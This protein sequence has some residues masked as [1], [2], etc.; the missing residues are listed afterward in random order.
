MPGLRGEEIVSVYS[1]RSFG[2]AA[3]VLLC[4]LTEPARAQNA[5]KSAVFLKGTCE[6]L[7]TPSGNLT[8]TC[9]DA[10]VSMQYQDGRSSFMFSDGDRSMISFS[11]IGQQMNGDTA[12]LQVDHISI[13]RMAA[14]DATEVRSEDA[15]GTCEF[16]NVYKGSV[17]IRCTG[18][19]ASGSFT[20]SFK[21][22]GAKPDV[23]NF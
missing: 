2:M 23:V 15:S 5:P 6:Q 4:F 8:A 17:Y 20:A 16:G 21:T 12:N 22:D 7:M 19:T 11:G 1:R 9:K 3:A 14:S 18:K 10:L 13:A